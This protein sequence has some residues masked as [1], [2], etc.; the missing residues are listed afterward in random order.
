MSALP[1]LD[2]PPL[3]GAAGTVRLP[4]SKSISNR[5]LL[6]AGLAAGTTVIHDLLESD[7]TQVMLEALR[8]LGC[9]VEARGADWHITG[10][11]GRLQ[12]T[13]GDPTPGA[14]RARIG[15][16]DASKR[17]AKS[18]LRGDVPVLFL[19]SNTLKDQL[20][21]M[22]G[23]ITP[24]GGQ[25][26]WPSWLP[27]EFFIELCAEIRNLKGWQNPRR[28]RNEAWDLLYYCLGVLAWYQLDRW[29]W[30]NPPT[31]ALPAHEGNTLC[32]IIE[33]DAP[34]APKFAPKPAE[35]H[36]VAVDFARALAS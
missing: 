1:F 20:D 29:D 12:L 31:W 23:R 4:G 17:D 13:K 28:H 27:D 15:Y 22:V 19:A 24:G 6:L 8:T 21:N 7:D 26:R 33:P 3:D 14:P 11:G 35:V 25:I 5:V 10:L 2:L 32:Q 36:N 30:A 16:P 9:G 18:P 34:Q